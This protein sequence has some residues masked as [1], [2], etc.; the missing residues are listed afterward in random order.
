MFIP[1]PGG[2]SVMSPATMKPKG[3][4]FKSKLETGLK[5]PGPRSTL[6]NFLIPKLPLQ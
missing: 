5:G 6:L 4:F 1:D 3:Q 2:P